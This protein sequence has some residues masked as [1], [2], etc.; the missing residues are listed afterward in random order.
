VEAD[1]AAVY[2]EKVEE[3]MEG[4]PDNQQLQGNSGQDVLTVVADI[5][6]GEILRSEGRLDE[7]I[8]VL[9]AAADKHDAFEYAEPEALNFS[10]RHRLG[11]ALLEAE[12]YAEAEDVYRGALEQHPHNVGP[13]SASPRR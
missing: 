11:A 4:L 6:H 8:E 3:T 10:A 2:L 1:S 9:Q 13:S 7:A 12:R 5:L